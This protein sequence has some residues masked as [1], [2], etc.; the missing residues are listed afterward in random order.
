MSV[1]MQARVQ[2]MTK[3]MADDMFSDTAFVEGIKAAP[4]FGGLSVAGP[5]EGGW[6][7]LEL[8]DNEGSHQAWVD[9]FVAPKMPEGA[10]DDVEVT[11]HPLQTVITASS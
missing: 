7:V 3:E 9:S 11:Y 4:G 5:I 10:L 2:G 1:L 8:W 6:Q